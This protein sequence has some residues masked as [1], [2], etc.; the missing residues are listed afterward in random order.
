MTDIKQEE[1][2]SIAKKNRKSRASG[3][4]GTSIIQP[5]SYTEVSRIHRGALSTLK[6]SMVV[7][8]ATAGEGTTLLAHLMA[9]RSAEAGRKTL[10]V[11]LN[12]RNTELSNNLLPDRT[13][14]NLGGRNFAEG[15]G[16][17]I[18]P[19]SDPNLFFMPAPLDSVSVQFL[20]DMSHAGAFFDALEKSFEH[21]VVDTTPIGSLNRYNIDPVTLSAAARRTVLVMMANRTHKDK[22]HKAVKQ[23]RE[24][25]ANVEGMVVNDLE[26]PSLRSQLNN[27]ADFFKPFAP[28]FTQW[29][30]QK[31]AKSERLD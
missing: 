7:T 30:R 18:H 17:L 27:F 11:D 10:L 6:G 22:V 23:L 15:F 1:L 31:I 20:K 21:I 28:G 29:M 26:N 3:T 8:A 24:S 25:G 5:T 14:W 19:T 2:A 16:D 9:Q 4:M 12:M 13:A